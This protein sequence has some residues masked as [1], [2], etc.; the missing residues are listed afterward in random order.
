MLQLRREAAYLYDAVRIY[1]H[2]LAQTIGGV[3][4]DAG[5]E[6]DVA[7]GRNGTLLMTHIV[8][9]SYFRYV[10]KLLQVD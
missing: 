2:A 1:A 3:P 10:L 4:A 9:R 7:A 6:A 5:P 8:N